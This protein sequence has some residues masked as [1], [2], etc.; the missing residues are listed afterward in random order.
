MPT[1]KRK[2]T[3][4]PPLPPTAGYDEE[5]AALEIEPSLQD[6]LDSRAPPSKR[7]HLFTDSA[8]RHLPLETLERFLPLQ[9][10][11]V[12]TTFVGQLPP[13]PSTDAELQPVATSTNPLDAED[14]DDAAVFHDKPSGS[15][16]SKDVG[17][18]AAACVGLEDN[19]LTLHAM[20]HAT[21]T[22]QESNS[23]LLIGAS[24]SGKSLLV[25]SVLEG[26]SNGAGGDSRPYY[27]VHLAGTVQINDRSAM[28][29][30]AQQL[31][32]QGAFSE[33]DVASAL[34]PEPTEDADDEDAGDHVF[35]G[36]D[37]S[38]STASHPDLG[39][40]DGD[41]EA[42]IQDELAGAILSSL[43]NIIAHIISLLS[44][45]TAGR[46]PLIITLDDFDLFTARPRQAMLYCLL[47]AVQAA[48]YGSGLAVVGLTGR[49]DTVDLL[50]KRV[51]SR[52][53]HRILHVRPPGSWEVF[54]RVVRNAFA[55]IAIEQV[56]G[57]ERGQMEEF[58][59]AWKEDVKGLFGNT[60]FREVLR[61]IYELS[62]DIRLAYRILTPTIAA[63]SELSPTFDLPLLLNT[64][65]EEVGDSML[66]ILRDLTEPELALL[67]SI[68]HLQ[69]RDRQIFNFE[70]CFDELRRFAARDARERQAAGSTSTVSG[71]NV[72][73][74]GTAVAVPFY[75][76][77]KIALMAFHA[78]LSLEILLPENWVTGLTVS[79][80]VAKPSAAPF[81]SSQTGRAN[82]NTIRKEFW[83][84]R[85]ILM[86]HMIVQAVKDRFRQVPINSSLVK[87]ASSHG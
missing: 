27:H 84:V 69:T 53:S 8:L 37:D 11:R 23:C 59:E 81:A 75:A 15:A 25:N 42:E 18:R 74:G 41:E 85:C 54:E 38:A 10:R 61:G 13:I 6:A 86:P 4:T 78:L 3:E 26:L 35:G 24:G 44:S 31:I 66:S 72:A 52:F 50:E 29:E 46:K 58:V 63:L 45:G 40:G 17:R 60:D 30:M 7:P 28:K 21:V 20:L 32:L 71:A 1:T 62:N 77:R 79:N 82:Q 51:K 48:S 19:F 56:G 73:A 12:L 80:P 76:D 16:A 34:D 33:D 43:N 47:D 55:P 49:V 87:W 9:K 2:A 14:D 68:K 70:M 83:K 64:A 67:I 65:S 39:A 22:A 57:V 36:G 5:D